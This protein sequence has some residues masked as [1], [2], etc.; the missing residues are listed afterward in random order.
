MPS[1]TVIA[2]DWSGA[3]GAGPHPGIWFT[4]VCDGQIDVNRGFWGRE[5]IVDHLLSLEGPLTVGL[6]FSFGFP[7]WVGECHGAQSGT[8]LWAITAKDGERW[9]SE[10]PK[11]FWGPKGTRRPVD[12]EVFRRCER[13]LGA[14]ST[15]QI[16][17]PGAVG[18]GAIRGM[19]L[20]AQL[21]AAGMSIW[22]FDAAGDRTVI[23]IYPRA[24]LERPCVVGDPTQRDS[25]A[26]WL[27]TR[28]PALTSPI[29][30]TTRHSADAFDAVVAAHAMW[31][32]RD[33]LATLAAAPEPIKQ[34]EGA[35]WAPNIAP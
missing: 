10:C 14:K 2:I 28:W 33:R 35:I 13:T 1:P 18:T 7:A 22:P 4:S 12:L 20:L 32:H 26:Q 27:A 9:L 21:R 3:R 25:Y 24:C 30:E 6:D 19:P 8:E 23:E 29:V 16:A 5:E 11:P 15:F 31:E 34:L 17:N